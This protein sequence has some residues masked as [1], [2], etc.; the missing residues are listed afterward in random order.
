MV[1]VIVVVAMGS[2]A[3]QRLRIRSGEVALAALAVVGVVLGVAVIPA[4]TAHTSV[5]GPLAATLTQT[6][7]STL[8][9]EAKQ[10]SAQ[11]RLN[12]WDV[13]LG[14]AQQH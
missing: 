4:V 9:S 12:K 13:A 1:T 7:G 11:D 6:V 5:T 8:N 2:T 3:R 14:D 10:Q